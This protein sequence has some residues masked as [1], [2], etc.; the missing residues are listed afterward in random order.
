MSET[1]VAGVPSRFVAR[2]PIFDCDQ[3]VTGYEL[4]HRQTAENVFVSTDPDLASKKVMDTAVLVGLS[5]LSNGHSLFINC[6]RD[7]IVNG[8]VTLFSP[9]LTVVEILETVEPDP[10]LIAACQELKKAGY[11]IAL[12]DFVDHP[13]FAP[14]TKL[15]DI[16]KVDFRL[17]SVGARAEMAAKYGGN[18]RQLLAEKIET[19]DE[20]VSAVQLGYT[21]FQGYFFCKPAIVSTRDISASSAT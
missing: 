12:D 20:F 16:I 7:F 11:R 1:T 8:Y 3:K 19:H 9:D 13:R 2:Q 14:L 4:L 6:P 18:R 17:S 21:L 15:A 5:V 10:Q